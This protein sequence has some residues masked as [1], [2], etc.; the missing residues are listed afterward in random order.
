MGTTTTTN[1]A[2]RIIQIIKDKK[3]IT[4]RDLSNLLLLNNN[5]L[6]KTILLLMSN[7]EICFDNWCNLILINKN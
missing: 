4:K 5:K 7:E 1:L 6:D 2:E 3:K